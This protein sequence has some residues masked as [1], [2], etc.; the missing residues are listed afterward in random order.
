MDVAIRPARPGDIPRMAELLRDLFTRE[1]DFTPDLEKQMRGLS[2]LV[3]DPSGR[4]AVL[5]ADRAGDIVGMTTVQT[6]LSTSEGGR[7]GLVEDVVVDRA[8]R[9]RGIGSRL[10]EEAATWSTRKG[11]KRLQLLADGDNLA[12]L[13]FYRRRRWN[14]T[15]LVCLRQML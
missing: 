15:R 9:G 5:V 10:L 13:E 11:L 7:V 3:A 14:S 6:L 8:V 1:A 2:A 12:A 4:S